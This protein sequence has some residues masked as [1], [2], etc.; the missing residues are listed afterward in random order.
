MKRL[1]LAAS[2]ALLL[3]TIPTFAGGKPLCNRNPGGSLGADGKCHTAVPVGPGTKVA[4][5][6]AEMEFR[7]DCKA[8]GGD[9]FTAV[10]WNRQSGASLPPGALHC[11][12][13]ARWVVDSN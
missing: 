11:H 3:A 4:D 5:A 9:V 12:R 13:A 1:I 7:A 6:A 2:V 8:H 10:Q